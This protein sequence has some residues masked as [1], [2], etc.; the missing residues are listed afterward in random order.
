MLSLHTTIFLLLSLFVLGPTET[1]E[2]LISIDENCDN[3]NSATFSQS[4]IKHN[5]KEYVSNLIGR[6]Y[7]VFSLL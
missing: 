6:G 3:R 4:F 7:S 1:Q 5:N 2:Q